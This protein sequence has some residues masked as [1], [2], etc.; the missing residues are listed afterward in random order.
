MENIVLEVRV[1]TYWVVSNITGSS[2]YY[3]QFGLPF[4]THI[5][6]HQFLNLESHNQTVS[7]EITICILNYL[8]NLN[9]LSE[10]DQLLS[11]TPAQ[12]ESHPPN[13]LV[14]CLQA[15]LSML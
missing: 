1:K 11:I 7:N 4:I 14:F 6:T 10:I 9:S 3:R 12:T 8:C 5:Y 15:T 13:C 2:I